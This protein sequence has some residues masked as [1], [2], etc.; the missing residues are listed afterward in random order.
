EAADAV[1]PVLV[2]LV[3]DRLLR[4]TEGVVSLAVELLRRQAAEVAHAGRGE[5]DQRVQDLTRA[6]TAEGDV[7]ADGLALAQL[8]LRDRLLRL[9]D[10]G[11]LTGDRGEVGDRTLDDLA[12][13]SRLADASVDDDLDDAGNLHDVRVAELLL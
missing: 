5:R 4:H 11:L 8:E 3:E 7:R 6:V 10:D 2:D 12:V 1:D 13:A 9:G